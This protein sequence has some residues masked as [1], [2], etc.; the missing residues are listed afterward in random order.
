MNILFGTSAFDKVF[1]KFKKAGKNNWCLDALAPIRYEK[2]AATGYLLEG[3]HLPARTF[4]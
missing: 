3:H 2:D 1:R 4:G